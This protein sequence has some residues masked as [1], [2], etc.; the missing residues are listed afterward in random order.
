MSRIVVKNLP[1]K[2]KD[3]KLSGLFSSIGHITDLSLKYTKDGV[4]RK[5]AF[6]GF[7]KEGDAINAI[8][9]FNNTFI[10]ASKIQVELCRDLHDSDKPRAWS[11]YAKGTSAYK[12]M[13][14]KLEAK[15]AEQSGEK[16]Q[17]EKKTDKKEKKKN[18]RDKKVEELFGDL[19]DD[20]EFQDFLEVHQN[21][22]NKALWS[23]DMVIGA[24]GGEAVEPVAGTSGKGKSKG[25]E[26]D[27][28]VSDDSGSSEEE[29][30]VK[31]ETKK[32]VK[33]KVK[34][35]DDIAVKKDLSDLDYLKSK[36]SKSS[37]LLTED[38][39]D[40]ESSSSSDNDDDDSDDDG[41]DESQQAAA[42][43]EEEKA[44][45][46]ET[47]F[48]VKLKG[49]PPN[50]KDRQIKEFFQGIMVK[51]IQVP[52]NAA[53]KPIGVAYA[54]FVTEN[55]LEQALRRNKSFIG[56]KKVFLKKVEFENVAEGPKG[57]QLKPWEAKLLKQKAEGAED[58]EDETIAESGRLFVRNLAYVCKEQDLEDLFGKYGPITDVN[59]P[60]DK[61]TKKIKG[62]AFVTF[63]MPEHA[64]KAFMELDG[65]IFQ[66][67]LLHILPA[68]TKEEKPLVEETDSF[69]KKRAAEKKA[70]SGSS[71]N[72][73]TLFLGANAV[74]DIMAEKYGKSKS[75]ILDAESRESLGVRMA[76]G[77]TQIVAETRDFLTENGLSLD[78]FSQ[79]SGPRSKTVILVKN[80]PAGTKAAEIKD[81][82]AK[83]GTLGRVILPPSGITAVV[84]FSEITEAK[85]AFRS[86]AYTKFQHVPLYLEW[87]PGEVFEKPQPVAMETGDEAGSSKQPENEKDAAS[88]SDDDEPEPDS[89]LF[90]KNINFDTTDKD[91][92]EKFSKCGPIHSASIAKKKDMK[93]PG[94]MLSMGYG[95]VQFRT[96]AAA[97]KALK[98]L[99]HSELDGHTLELKVSNRQTQPTA[100]TK[101]KEASKKVQ[102][103][104]KIMVRNIPFEAKLKEIEQLFKV[105][106]ELKSARLPKKLSGTGSHRGFGFVDFLSKQD[107]KRAF[108]ALC[109]STHLYG[110]RLVLEWAD[111]EETVDELRKK[112]AEHFHDEVPRKKLKKSTLMD[113]LKGVET[114]E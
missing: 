110:R 15:K 22:K 24:K 51:N 35:K 107:A 61:F 2:V 39:S 98:E 3:E 11:K 28:G 23:N 12:R 29:E 114:M 97:S 101:R 109:H 27:S 31:T 67:R 41:N 80:L 71:H 48:K 75:D 96:H 21:R 50:V 26:F 44:V 99:Q 66:G 73:N 17:E 40:E 34:A 55:D 85:T 8:K 68:K 113:E 53:K 72:W 1:S 86:L 57:K 95:F 45:H 46:Q 25:K 36:V 87:A 52:R 60:I 84:E 9:K 112:T 92:E 93:N 102:K 74:A 83:Y 78:S 33:T 64:V 111:E 103:S 88:S 19:K 56:T 58:D 59:L 42:K 69:K 37:R 13:M 91:L 54:E 4:F 90:V 76:L 104:T 70:L 47:K 16:P 14:E 81:V 20:A 62:F 6:I 10:E 5:F 94:Q 18:A 30:E 38:S 108:N 100:K 7:G 82:F 106:G 63:M 89:V 49:L 105:F 79:A 77:E 65:T 43:E 32:A